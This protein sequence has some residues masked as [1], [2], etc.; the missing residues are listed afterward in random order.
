MLFPLMAILSV[1][2]VAVSGCESPP[3]APDKGTS[4][5]PAG[6]RPSA[7]SPAPSIDWSKFPIPEGTIA[8]YEEV[9]AQVSPQGRY[10]FYSD[11][12]FSLQ[13]LH[14]SGSL[15]QY[16]GKYVRLSDTAIHFLFAWSSGNAEADGTLSG[17]TLTVKYNEVLQ[18]EGF[19]NGVFIRKNE[20]TAP[21]PPTI[22]GWYLFPVPAGAT[23]YYRVTPS[24]LPHAKRYVFYN[25][26][27]FAA[28]YLSPWGSLYDYGGRFVRQ[29]SI[30]HL[31]FDN[32]S[33][34]GS[35]EARATLSGDSLTVRYNALM[36]LDDFEDGIF[37]RGSN[38]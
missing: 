35:W 2:I 7:P 25:D 32:G 38:P 27:A 37:V 29:D 18:W 20:P 19:E 26:S 9:P 16:R 5:P 30:I 13:Y 22:E 6:S 31:Y 14:A 12:L 28:Q 11:S 33:V 24:Y 21:E 17:E 1:G 3:L 36:S 10:V 8:Y 4:P 23:A 15:V 34:A